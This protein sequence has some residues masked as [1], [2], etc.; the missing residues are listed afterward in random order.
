MVVCDTFDPAMRAR[1]LE[2]IAEVAGL[3]GARR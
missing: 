2:I 1:S 3:R